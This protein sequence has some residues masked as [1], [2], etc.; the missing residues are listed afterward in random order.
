MSQESPAS[1]LSGWYAISLRPQNLHAGVRSAAARWGART[2]AV[3]TLRLQPLVAGRALTDALRCTLIIATSPA[4][5]RM[6]QAQQA[7][8]RARASTWLA[9]G[10]GSALALRRCGIAQA[11]TPEHGAD[12]QALL[13]HPALADVRGQRIGLISAP[14]GRGVLEETLRGRGAHVVVAHVYRRDVIA[15]AKT[16]LKAMAHLPAA[17]L[18]VSS[19]EAF[20]ALW[21]QLDQSQRQALSRRPAVASSARLTQLLAGHGFKSLATADDARPENLLATLAEHVVNN[22]FR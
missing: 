15:V 21:A 1:P 9:V 11:L 7:L 18:L 5:V 22:R 4:A 20:D 19:G 6:A 14:G 3:S 12:S 16:R 10:I 2:F 8:A 17:A 13:A